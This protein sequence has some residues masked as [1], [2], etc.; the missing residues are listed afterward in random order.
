MINFWE[1]SDIS[2]NCQI[3]TNDEPFYIPITR[4]DLINLRLTIPYHIITLNGGGLPISAIEMKIVDEVGTTTLCDYSNPATGRFLLGFV[5]DLD[6]R[7]AHYQIITGLGLADENSANYAMYS[8]SVTTNDVIELDVNGTVYSFCYGQ[9]VT[10]FPLIEWAS[11]KLCISLTAAEHGSTT[12]TKN[13]VVTAI[14]SSVCAVPS[15]AHEDFDC[16]RFKVSVTF[17]TL[18]ITKHYYT[19]PYKVLRCDEPSVHIEAQYPVGTIDCDGQ[20]HNGSGA[21]G[22]SF[23]F[24]RLLMRVPGGIEKLPSELEKSYNSRSYSYR[25]SITKRYLLKSPPLPQWFADSF[26]TAIAAKTTLFDG[27]EYLQN[28]TNTIF[29][30]PEIIGTTYQNINL[31]LQSSKCEKV[32]VCQ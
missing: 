10:P 1:E 19:K 27:V 13:G 12:L 30:N 32:F 11:G 2:N 23:H 18:G 25:S 9:D 8:F 17:S 14:S 4:R 16:F 26:E 7:S 3:G 29:E 20:Y 31:N 15:C 22:A 21:S 28:N 5:N 24:N 6:N